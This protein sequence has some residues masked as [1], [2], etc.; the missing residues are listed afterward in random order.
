MAGERPQRPFRGPQ[1]GLR[2]ASQGDTEKG[3]GEGR[4]E[5]AMGR[6]RPALKVVSPPAAVDCKDP[7][8]VPMEEFCSPLIMGPELQRPRSGTAPEGQLW[9]PHGKRK[10]AL[11]GWGA[12]SLD[13][14]RKRQWPRRQLGRGGIEGGGV[15]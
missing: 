6:S 1:E 14:K 12:S 13:D 9:K 4:G 2:L 11:P 10:L 5:E 3:E 15:A 8:Q 7:P